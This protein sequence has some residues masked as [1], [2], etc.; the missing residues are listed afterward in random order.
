MLRACYIALIPF[1]ARAFWRVP[2]PTGTSVAELRRY[3]Q[4]SD[5]KLIVLT[6]AQILFVLLMGMLIWHLRGQVRALLS[7][8]P[9]MPSADGSVRRGLVEAYRLR[10]KRRTER[11]YE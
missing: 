11:V 3:G 2:Q 4:A 1:L 6:V 9:T 10:R 7:R 8:P 5:T